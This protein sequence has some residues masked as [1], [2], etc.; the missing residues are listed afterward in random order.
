MWN[1][2]LNKFICEIAQKNNDLITVTGG[3]NLRSD[4][5]SIE[6]FL[7]TIVYMISV[8]ACCRNFSNLIKKIFEHKF[9]KQKVKDDL[10]EGCFSINSKR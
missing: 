1:E 3:P 7:K 6:S 9:K 5:K 4:N 8:F 2:N 10:I